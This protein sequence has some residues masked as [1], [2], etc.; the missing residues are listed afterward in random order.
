MLFNKKLLKAM[1][2][3]RKNGKVER[4]VIFIVVILVTLIFVGYLF[5]G[6]TLPT[7]LPKIN[8]TNELINI[9]PPTPGKAQDSLQ[10]HTF[11]GATLT[12]YPT[13]QPNAPQPTNNVQLSGA[14]CPSLK[15]K[16]N[17][18]IIWSYNLNATKA[19]GNQLAV[20]VHYTAAQPLLL[21]SGNVT[22]M[23]KSPA[24]HAANPSVGNTNV[25]DA[26][27]FP[28][29]PAI[30]I[31]DITQNQ[32]DTSGDA[33]EGGVPNNPSDIYGAWKAAGAFNP[34][35]PNY[36]QLGGG[37]DTPWPPANGPGGGNRD[38]TWGAQVV[39]KTA[40]LKTKTGQ[41]LQ[42]GRVY[43]MQIVLHD[44]QGTGNVAQVC[45]YFTMPAS[46]TNPAP[47]QPA[48]GHELKKEVVP[49]VGQP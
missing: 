38:T 36:P 16:E 4:G 6:G 40:N 43:R 25:K 19:S 21:G 49:I 44:G 8:K 22:T 29:S 46:A 7:K 26:D 1:K 17:P 2:K 28:Y 45:A 3:R 5:V 47:S 33:Q 9:I 23:K 18:E 31:T 20:N 39:W 11:Y 10:L 15:G 32:N 41:T 13:Q 30:Y 48:M 35:V 37:D 24:D 14:Q 12:P 27:G 42:A 34:S